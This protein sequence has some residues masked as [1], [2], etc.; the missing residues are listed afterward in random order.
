MT[1][2]NRLNK[3]ILIK[4]KNLYTILLV[5]ILAVNIGFAAPKPKISVMGVTPETLLLTPALQGDSCVT[6]GLNIV[7][8]N[9]YVYLKVANIGD[10]TTITSSSWSFTSKPSGSN[11][12][13]VAV[14]A[15]NW[16]KFRPDVNGQ[17]QVKVSITTSSGS[18][19]TTLNIYGGNYVG[20]GNFQGISPVYPQCMSCHQNMPAFA[21]IFNRWKVSGHANIFRQEIDSGAAYYGISCMKCHTTGYDHNTYAVNNGFDDKARSLGWIW[22][23][24]APPKPGNWD[25]LKTNY[26]GLV[27][28]ATIGC[29]S[30]HGAGSEHAIGGDT[31]KIAVSY[32][33]AVCNSCHDEPW[34][35]DISQM[36]YNSKHNSVIWSSSFAQ[37]PSSSE[38]MTNSLG[39]CIRCHDGRGYTNL[40]YGKGTNTANMI[41]A[42]QTMVGCSSCHDPHGNSK[43]YSLR[44]RP[45]IADTMSNGYSY[46]NM[47]TG[48]V[49]FDCHQARNNAVKYVQT[50][51]T[52]SHWGPHD[53][54]QGDVLLGVNAANFG[55]PY[56]SGSHRNISGGCVGCHMAAT[57]DTG[58][59]TRDK[60]GGHSMNMR[61]DS[62][63]YDHVTGCVGCHP[64]VTSFDDFI[65]PQDFDGN[66][67]IESWQKEVA[68]TLRNLRIALPPAGIDSVNWQLIAADSNN[69]NLR[70]AYWNYQMIT[71]DGSLGIHN[72]FYVIQVLLTSINYTVGISPIGK[73]VPTVYDISQN[74][75]NPFNPST[76]IDF[77]LP[78]SSFVTLKVYDMSGREVATLLNSFITAGKY[79]VSWNTSESNRS[80]SSGVYFYRITTSTGFVMTKK[81]VL[82]K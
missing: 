7:G 39:N 55:V 2:T 65:A 27:Q 41:S 76:K 67:L 10:A 28:H 49:C 68:G 5:L 74:Y 18:K 66:G 24:F 72:P 57:T 8:L 73:E 53:G 23:H 25:S 30:C 22:S 69:I 42:D 17:Y 82:V 71:N 35:H 45:A 20:V 77:A 70:K 50:K 1:M 31:T 26:T 51:V 79:S 37:G 47:G 32:N 9:T 15:L 33:A 38:Y 36:F 40:Y 3:Q 44:I 81:M 12:S 59:V 14:T 29:E 75:P 60:V 4:M 16:M 43:P 34:R 63:N 11:A 61:Y 62:T 56:I 52:N 64:G 6:T 80:L 46:A 48:V 21:D 54:V 19:D 13:L 78:K 58:T